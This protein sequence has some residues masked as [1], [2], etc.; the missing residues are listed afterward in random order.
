MTVRE[1]TLTYGRGEPLDVPDAPIDTSN[2]A[3]RVL[4]PLLA[5]AAA[6]ILAH[7]HPS[8]VVRPSPDDCTATEAIALALALFKIRLLDHLIL[9]GDACYSIASSTAGRC[10]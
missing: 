7:N 10:R 2:A 4:A 6:V 9:A 1:L 5:N 3:A 8:G